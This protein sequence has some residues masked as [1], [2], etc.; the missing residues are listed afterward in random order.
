MEKRM[1]FITIGGVAL[2]VLCLILGFA[3]T[4]KGTPKDAKELLT[5][6]SEL[7]DETKYVSGKINCEIVGVQEE[8]NIDVNIKNEYTYDVRTNVCNAKLKYE[9]KLGEAEIT[10][11]IYIWNVGEKEKDETVYYAY[12]QTEEEEW[13]KEKITKTNDEIYRLNV[14]SLI[15]QNKSELKLQEK[16]KKINDEDCYVVEAKISAKVADIL[17]GEV[18]ILTAISEDSENKYDVTLYF[19]KKWEPVK[20][21]MDFMNQVVADSEKDGLAVVM[22]KAIFEQEYKEFKS[23]RKLNLPDVVK[24]DAVL[25]T[26]NNTEG[27]TETSENE[28]VFEYPLLIIDEN[29]SSVEIK[30]IKNLVIDNESTT[31]DYAKFYLDNIE[32][33]NYVEAYTYNYTWAETDEQALKLLLESVSNLEQFLNT[34]EEYTDVTKSEIKNT[35]INDRDVYT[36]DMTYKYD[37]SLFHQTDAFIKIQDKEYLRVTIVVVTD[38]E[39]KNPV[40]TDAFIEKF[41]KAMTVVSQEE[42]TK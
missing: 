28:I 33:Y 21:Y 42:V 23:F 14:F 27:D 38:F 1:K 2:L 35:K 19:N 31:G 30:K 32:E 15:L 13:Y 16:T 36:V 7:M 22:E 3:L 6:A 9:T 41:I 24:K 8:Q 40:D 10:E 4:Y 25:L 12:T 5:Y 29:T 17:T 20:I 39:E 37:K 26:T 11:N 34:E 18:D